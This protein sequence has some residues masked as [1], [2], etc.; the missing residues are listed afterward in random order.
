MGT[1]TFTYDKVDD[2]YL[3]VIAEH[4]NF[5]GRGIAHEMSLDKCLR[6]FLSTANDFPL[7]NASFK[8]HGPGVIAC[9]VRPTNSVGHLEIEMELQEVIGDSSATIRSA[10]DYEELKV[11]RLQLR[12][13]ADGD[14]SDF[15][16]PLRER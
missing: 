12:K 15:S 5:R 7:R 9:A 2:S 14:V 4:G 8:A 13:L 16:L 11:L 10:L 3:E 6:E 1:V